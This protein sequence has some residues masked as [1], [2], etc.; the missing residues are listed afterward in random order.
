[1]LDKNQRQGEKWPEHYKCG[2]DLK[3]SFMIS[4]FLNPILSEPNHDKGEKTTKKKGNK[5]S[6]M[7]LAS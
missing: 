6:S 5:T 4:L 2:T 7:K 1:V 3:D